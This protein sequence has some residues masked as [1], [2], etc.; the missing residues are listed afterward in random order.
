MMNHEVSEVTDRAMT[1][2][3]LISHLLSLD[4]GTDEKGGEARILFT[5]DYGDYGHTQ[6]A[7]P[8]EEAD[9]YC[10]SNL[11]TTGH[12][13]SGI[14]LERDEPSDPSE[15]TDDDYDVILLQS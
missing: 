7:I 5:C 2:R 12:S 10:S 14:C 4:P 8:V 13:T 9:M 6:Q 11:H 1:T 15:P 3:Q